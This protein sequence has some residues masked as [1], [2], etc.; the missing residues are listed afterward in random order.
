MLTHGIV[1]QP[2]D[3][4]IW[5][6]DEILEFQQVVDLIFAEEEFIQLF[7]CLKVSQALNLVK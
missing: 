6:I 3:A 4:Q 2:K 5:Q 1:L 7:T